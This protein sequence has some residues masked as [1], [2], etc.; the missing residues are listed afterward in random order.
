MFVE[1]AATFTR[2][3]VVKFI[4]NRL[5]IAA[6]AGALALAV[7]LGGAFA[8]DA[9]AS[10]RGWNVLCG[11]RL[12]LQAIETL[13]NDQV[14]HYVNSLG[15]NVTIGAFQIDLDQ[16]AC[17][18]ENLNHEEFLAAVVGEIGNLREL[19]S[20]VTI[21]VEAHP[22]ADH[23]RLIHRGGNSYTARVWS[24]IPSIGWA[25]V[26]QDFTATV[27]RGWIGSFSMV[28]GSYQT[29]VAVA[30]WGGI[31]SWGVLQPNGTRLEIHMRGTL[32]YGIPHTPAHVSTVATF[33]EFTRGHG[34]RLVRDE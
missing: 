22:E 6:S 21:D 3:T 26:N 24:G 16:S 18:V 33:V 29:G 12:E 23:A 8:T 25:Y 4:R 28:G 1:F 14:T 9:V 17:E 20:S 5:A 7:L 32:S 19:F 31:N 13:L 11:E 10:E 30:S 34:D 2:S 27:N 15:L